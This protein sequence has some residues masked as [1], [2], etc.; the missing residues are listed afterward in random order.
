MFAMF[1]KEKDGPKD[2]MEVGQR[3]NLGNHVNG[4]DLTHSVGV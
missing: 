3:N 2:P 4:K 1:L